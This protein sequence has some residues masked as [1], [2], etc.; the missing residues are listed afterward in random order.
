MTPHD[1]IR[2]ERP[3]REAVHGGA[4]V[5]APAPRPTGDEARR[6]R[7]R[8]DRHGRG[9]R[10]PLLSQQ[11][12]GYRTRAELFD[13]LVMDAVT[14]L[15]DRWPDRLAAIEFAV[16]EV[17]TIPPDAVLASSDVVVDEGVPLARFFPP[18]LDGRGRQT[19]P[20]IVVY[21]RPIELRAPVPTDLVDLVADV[22]TEQLEA[23]LGEGGA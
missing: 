6:R 14:D 11:V 23:V 12:P 16:D 5:H 8:L 3:T 9:M 22:L 10:T 4:A 13:Q 17:P 2:A 20:R 21:R 18:G 15:E 1:G 7:R 19:K